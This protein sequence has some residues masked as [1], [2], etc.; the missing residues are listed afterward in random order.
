MAIDVD[1]HPE[2]NTVGLMSGII[3]DAQELLKSQL[4]LFKAELKQDVAK[5]REG[6]SLLA[7]GAGLCFVALVILTFA[8]A[9]LLASVM[10]AVP[11][12]GWY[13]LVGGGVGIIGLSVLGVVTMQ[14]NKAKPLSETAAGLEENVKWTTNPK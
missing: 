8:L 9:H 1:N 10:P 12:W 7:V 11:L 6:T 3:K 2:V 5:A 13:A 14:I 4:Q